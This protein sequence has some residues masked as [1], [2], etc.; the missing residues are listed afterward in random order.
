MNLYAP[1]TVPSHISSLVAELEKVIA[2]AT[3]RGMGDEVGE[4]YSL[5]EADINGQLR[6]LGWDATLA[7]SG[8][9][10][11]IPAGYTVINNPPDPYFYPQCCYQIPER[12]PQW[13]TLWDEGREVRFAI[14]RDAY[15]F[16]FSHL[17]WEQAQLPGI[18]TGYAR[19]IPGEGMITSL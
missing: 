11:P 5:L 1:T 12:P 16:V 19:P 15:A 7:D 18:A 4:Q 13:R 6:S 2:A 9:W 10:V 8:H 17:T 3:A 14:W